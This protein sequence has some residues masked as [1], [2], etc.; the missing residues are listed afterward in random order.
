MITMYLSRMQGFLSPIL[1]GIKI[2][3]RGI[4]VPGGGSSETL[5]GMTTD[6]WEL[7]N[8]MAIEDEPFDEAISERL[9]LFI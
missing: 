5:K 3:R 7:K 2:N 8:I 1:P 9:R 4:N 6:S